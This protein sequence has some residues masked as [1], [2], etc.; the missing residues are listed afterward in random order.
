MDKARAMPNPC[1]GSAAARLH[2][3]SFF[4]DLQYALETLR[5][6]TPWPAGGMADA[7]AVAV[8]MTEPKNPFL[9]ADL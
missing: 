3:P 9:V 8:K 1:G 2:K 7:T 6:P 4:K 5:L